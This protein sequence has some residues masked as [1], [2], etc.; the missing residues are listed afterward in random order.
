MTRNELHAFFLA[1]TIFRFR[2]LQVF[3]LCRL[4]CG[5]FED[6]FVPVVDLTISPPYAGVMFG[7]LSS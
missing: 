6:S 5:Q 4:L 1:P 7:R 3:G 2:Q